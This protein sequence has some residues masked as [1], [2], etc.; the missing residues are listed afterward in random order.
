MR[1]V[2]TLAAV[3]VS[4]FGVAA[5]TAHAQRGV[6]D[7]TGVAQQ[8]V[9]PEVVS[10]S[11]K[12]VEVKTGPCESTTGRS[13]SGTHL[14]L[15]TAEKQQLNVHLGP[16]EAVAATIAKL[17]VGQQL[18]VRAFRTE[19]MKE[20]H[21]VAQSLTFGK[22]KVELRDE[23]LRPAWAGR[24]AGPRGT[25]AGQAGPSEGRGPGRGRGQQRLGTP[26]SKSA[27]SKELA[28]IIAVT[29]VEPSLDAVV[30]PRFGRCPYFVL[31]DTEGKMLEAVKNTSTTRGNAG[32][33]ATEMLVK[34][35]VKV[36][37]TGQ[38][39]PSASAALATADIQVVQ[40]CSGT[41]RAAIKQFK[42]EPLQ[43]PTKAKAAPEPVTSKQE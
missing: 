2:V 20:K 31:V 11:G 4:L 15:E 8:P 18:V 10:L 14:I 1:H 35:G 26:Q 22:N 23:N 9:K 29:A 24:N 43:P 30:D 38:C 37:L 5:P 41:V 36:L 16:A 25:T 7:L 19:K 28:G 32:V 42:T 21:Y 33:Q 17:S 39:G 3:I 13:L 6:G 34:K 27:V 12:I 40:G